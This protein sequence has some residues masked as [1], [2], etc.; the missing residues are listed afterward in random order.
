MSDLDPR[1]LQYNSAGKALQA[2]VD[3]V[4]TA[5]D[6]EMPAAEQAFRDAQ[7]EFA[8]C[9]G[10]LRASEEVAGIPQFTPIGSGQSLTGGV[11]DANPSFRTFGPGESIAAAALQRHRDAGTLE[12]GAENLNMGRALRAMALGDW[13]GAEAEYRAL[14]ST[15]GGAGG[16]LIPEILASYFID[17]A[18]AVSV[19][20]QAGVPTIPMSQDFMGNSLSIA[21]ILTDPSLAWT[22]EGGVITPSEP[23][24]GA[25]NIAPKKLTCIVRASRELLRDAPN[26]DAMILMSLVGAFAAEIDRVFLEGSGIGSEPLGLAGMTIGEVEMAAGGA[27]PTSDTGPAKLAA[28]SLLVRQANHQPNAIVSSPRDWDLFHLLKD[29]TKQPLAFGAGLD[30]MPWHQTTTASSTLTHGAGVGVCG[31]IYM[32]DF[33]K[34]ALYMR[35]NIE[36]YVSRDAGLSNDEIVMQ[37]TMR[38][39][40]AVEDGGAFA[41]LVG[42]KA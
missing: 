4:R 42:V 15:T 8:R 14:S 39:D 32:G 40:T 12:Q 20:S 21:K 22:D 13:R 28:A 23:T 33:M 27:A 35:Q 25:L 6:A 41:R 11:P 2:A 17:R 16:F 19:I 1:V 37:A 5:S 36:I 26:A 31:N 30:D 10:N 7:K 3:N 9:E 29:S 38:L 34:A 24:F 18:R